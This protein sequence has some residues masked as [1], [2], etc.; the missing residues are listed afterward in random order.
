MLGSVV[1]QDGFHS[2]IKDGKL[3]KYIS[4][5]WILANQQLGQNAAVLQK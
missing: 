3:N 1:V 4:G 2:D 5:D